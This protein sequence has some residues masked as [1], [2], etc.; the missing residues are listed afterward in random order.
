MK[1]VLQVQVI[2]HQFLTLLC[3]LC[4]KPAHI[5]IM[6]GR[7]LKAVLAQRNPYEIYMYQ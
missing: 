6:L 3:K 4:L 1:N 2:T 5:A 7:L